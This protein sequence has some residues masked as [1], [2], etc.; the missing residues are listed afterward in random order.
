MNVV[1]KNIVGKVGKKGFKNVYGE[2]R[3]FLSKLISG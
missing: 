3:K 2:P 1:E